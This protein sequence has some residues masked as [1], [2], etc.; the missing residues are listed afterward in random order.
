MADFITPRHRAKG[1]LS[2]RDAA[3]RISLNH[4]R[5]TL[6]P[7]DRREIIFSEL[8]VPASTASDVEGGQPR[9][10]ERVSS[11]AILIH[12]GPKAPRNGTQ[13]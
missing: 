7:S 9:P 11:E 10:A 6:S 2:Q 1:N 4:I 12:V 5:S 13:E 3:P 8:S